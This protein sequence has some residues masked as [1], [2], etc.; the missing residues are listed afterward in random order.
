MKKY[1]PKPT[2][3]EMLSHE[4][5]AS[6]YENLKKEK[7]LRI[8]FLGD[9]TLKKI[10]SR[11]GWNPSEKKKMIIPAYTKVHFRPD[12]RLTKFFNS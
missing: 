2:I 6:F 9:F 10:K 1:S 3:F 11:E 4:V 7:K 5:A 8:P 12:A